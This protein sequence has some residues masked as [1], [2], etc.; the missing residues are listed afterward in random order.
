MSDFVLTYDPLDPTRFARNLR[1]LPFDKREQLISSNT[2]T[3][4]NERIL[5]FALINTWYYIEL[6]QS[7][8][9]IIL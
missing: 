1:H 4:T 8:T 9:N 3:N 6:S 5:Y 2:P 7:H